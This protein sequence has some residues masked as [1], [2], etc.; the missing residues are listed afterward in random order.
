MDKRE[1]LEL[2]RCQAC[3]A[4]WP[5]QAGPTSCPECGWLYVDWLTFSGSDGYGN[6]LP[7]SPP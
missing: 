6:L 7:L 4:E 3:K 1:R 5:G 2:Y